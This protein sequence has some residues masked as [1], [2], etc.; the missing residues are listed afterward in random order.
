MDLLAYRSVSTVLN[1]Y[2]MARVENGNIS[3]A[4]GNIVFYTMNGKNYAK[5]K[6]TPRKR[7][8]NEPLSPQVQQFSTASFYG[9]PVLNWLKP[10]LTFKFKRNTFNDFRKWLGFA[11]KQHENNASWPLSVANTLLHNINRES[12]IRDMLLLLPTVTADKTG[13]ISIKFSSFIPVDQIKA[14]SGTTEVQLKLITV[15]APFSNSKKNCLVQSAFYDF[16]YN[17]SR[18]GEKEMILSTRA[19]TGYMLF[20]IIAMVFKKAKAGESILVNDT[21]WLPAA[22]VAVGKL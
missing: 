12:E 21:E 11:I 14:P 6:S 1:Q 13:N 8:K 17:Q 10:Q 5:A 2:K 3:G 16:S 22:I 20:V 19:K 9:T 4:I 18:L 7:K 15:A